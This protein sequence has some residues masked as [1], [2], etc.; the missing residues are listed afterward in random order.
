MS[1]FL[2]AGLAETALHRR[3]RPVVKCCLPKF[4]FTSSLLDTGQQV[5]PCEADTGPAGDQRFGLAPVPSPVLYTCTQPVCLCTWDRKPPRVHRQCQVRGTLHRYSD[6]SMSIDSN[7]KFMET[8]PWLLNCN[9]D[10]SLSGPAS[11]CVSPKDHACAHAEVPTL[12][13]ITNYR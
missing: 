1:S 4:A 6:S 7:L 5:L 12:I 10:V 9:E 13:Y 3:C 11:Y 8:C 2:R